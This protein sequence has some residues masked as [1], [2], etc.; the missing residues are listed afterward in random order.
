MQNKPAYLKGFLWFAFSG[1]AMLSAFILPVHIWALSHGYHMD[2]P[3][4]PFR[5][6]FTVLMIAALYHSLYRV[7][8]ICFDLGFG[9]HEKAIEAF[10]AL[11]FLLAS[12][13]TILTASF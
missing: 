12:A 5:L 1:T 9:T 6:Y 10:C 13:T 4:W 7:K 11:L 2:F 8:T 3:W